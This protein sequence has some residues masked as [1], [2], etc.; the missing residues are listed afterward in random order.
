MRNWILRFI[1]TEMNVLVLAVGVQFTSH[2]LELQNKIM[3]KNDVDK[4]FVRWLR[5]NKV[6]SYGT[7]C[8]L[9]FYYRMG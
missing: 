2:V 5:V 7:Y 3:W 4:T 9:L 8:N 6:E 1:T